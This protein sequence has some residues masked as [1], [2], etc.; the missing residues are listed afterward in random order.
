MS[1][2]F[3]Y[4]TPAA[5]RFQRLLWVN[6]FAV[7]LLGLIAGMLLVFSMVGGFIIWPVLDFPAD[8]PG[9]V[10]GWKAAHVGGLTNGLLLL[11]IGAVVT[12]VPLTARA[13]RFVGWSFLLTGWGNTVF[14]WAGNL[15]PNRGVS[16]QANDYGEASVAGTIAFLGGGSVMLLTIVAT[17]MLMRAAYGMVTER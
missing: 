8:I 12:Q 11:F 5:R 4:Q 7:M 10:R 2:T 14:Y 17:A 16:V 3:D 15:A 1:E 6:G 13:L 9:S